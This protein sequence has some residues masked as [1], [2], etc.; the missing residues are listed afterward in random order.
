M[1]KR[2]ELSAA[3]ALV[4]GMSMISTAIVADDDDDDD[5]QGEANI[6]FIHSGDFHGDYHPHTNGRGDNAGRLEGGMARA[7]TKIQQLRKRNK[8]TIHVHTGDTIHGSGEAS[9]TKGMNMVRMVDQLG[10]DVSTPGN[11]EWAY[12]P[13]RYMQFFGVHD[14]DGNNL[15]IIPDDDFDVNANKAVKYKKD[16]P[17]P[18]DNVGDVPTFGAPFRAVKYV[19]SYNE[20]GTP[21]MAVGYNRWGMVAANAY[22]NGT[23]R[24]DHGLW[25]SR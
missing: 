9:I 17:Y 6:T 16:S 22:R 12:T 21:N 15:D 4:T 18:E 3:I 19:E 11:W 14:A 10:I 5:D 1:L 24:L 25:Y 13:Y 23:W 8:H 20:D 2:H 7:V